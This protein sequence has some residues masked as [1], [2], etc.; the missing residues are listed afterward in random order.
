MKRILCVILFMLEMLIFTG[1]TP[2]TYTLKRAA[3]EIERIEIVVANTSL[4]Y[5]V[6]KALSPMEIVHFLEEFQKIKFNTYYI[7]DPMS[8]YGDSVKITY[9]NGD[10]EM[11]CFYWSEYVEN[12]EIYYIKKNCNENEFNELLNQFLD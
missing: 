8:I 10:Y 4:D 12:G 6:K 9:Q 1:C 5:S 7:G 3:G 11:I 2:E